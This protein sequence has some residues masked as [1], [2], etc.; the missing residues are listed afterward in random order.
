MKKIIVFLNSCIFALVLS[1]LTSTASAQD[2]TIYP[3]KNVAIAL[4]YVDGFLISWDE[5]FPSSS[6]IDDYEIRFSEDS[7]ITWQVYADGIT[8]TLN[9]R[10]R[11]LTQNR[12]YS[13]QVRSRSGNLYSRWA[14]ATSNSISPSFVG[15]GFY[16]VC[17]LLDNGKIQ[18]WGNNNGGYL[19][20]GSTEDSYD[21]VYVS[22]ISD[23]V[24]LSTGVHS[25]AVL[26]NSRI[27][28][29]G[30]NDEGQLGDGTNTNRN[31]P[32]LVSGITNAVQVD[33]RG[34]SN[35]C[36]VLNNKTIKCWGWNGTGAL[37]DGTTANRLSP[38]LVEGITNAA[39]VASGSEHTCALLETGN[40][41][42]WGTNDNGQ[43]GDGSYESSLTPK[44]V[45]GIDNAIQ[46]TVGAFHTCALLQT[47]AIKC[48]GANQDGYLGDGTN[49]DRNVPISTSGI[50]NATQISSGVAMCAVLAN[51]KV[52]CWGA[53]DE[54][55]IGD[56]TDA[57]R[58]QPT[59]VS[60]LNNAVQVS[61]YSETC[62][63][64]SNKNIKCWG[65]NYAGALRN[66][67]VDGASFEPVLTYSSTI[68][69]FSLAEPQINIS[70]IGLQLAMADS[71]I[72]DLASEGDVNYIENYSLAWSTNQ[73]QWNYI[74]TESNSNQQSITNLIP[75]TTYFVK[76]AAKYSVGI[77]DY[78]IVESFS[79]KSGLPGKVQSVT[80]KLQKTKYHKF[81]VKSAPENGAPITG[82]SVRWKLSTSKKWG[83]WSSPKTATSFIING[84]IKNKTYS[85]QIKAM[86]EYGSSISNIFTLKQ[87]K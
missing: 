52:K 2:F 82:Y 40:V 17:T 3:P 38:V 1:G 77:S 30:A 68:D 31:S 63:L 73:S 65:A 28:C 49:I 87:T 62:A 71:L 81:V 24:Q 22:G 37:G 85:L 72:L 27:K 36:A 29:W 67:T 7:G 59:F 79:T 61:G 13:I 76:V 26:T 8:N 16:N 6:T 23:A 19:G 14:T 4:S 11:G 50:D 51:G 84:W 34:G 9:S 32:V 21:P 58:N 48:W 66:G 45:I 44:R 5:P 80:T 74:E 60:N 64:L 83:A 53:N 33:T 18:C 25:C 57:Y 78:S 39:Q 86:S 10:I 35:T 56:G 15:A 70:S 20:D 55:Q 47:G 41:E 54:G 46:I 69:T 75:S 43:L 42:C 12:N